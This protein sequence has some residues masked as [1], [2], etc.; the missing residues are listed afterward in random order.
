MP[1][2][3]PQYL[4]AIAL[5]CLIAG[6]LDIS[7]A[8]IFYG[9]RGVPPTRLLQNIASSLLGRAAFAQGVRSAILGLLLH[10]FIATTVATIYILASRQLPLSRRPIFYGFLY[11]IVVYIVMNYVVV[12]LSKIG[13]RPNP[14]LIPLTNGVAALIL[15][16]GIPIAFIARRY[17]PYKAA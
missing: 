14:R 7:D 8:L 10:Y 15:F 3:R 12:P 4:K 16:I 1:D 9:L 11:G 13:P 17:G 6:T 2:R 5:S